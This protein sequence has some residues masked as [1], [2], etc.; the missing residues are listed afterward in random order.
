VRF[1]GSLGDGALAATLSSADGLLLTRRPA[2]TEE[3]SFPTRLVEYLRH[4]RPVFVSNVGDVGRYLR[5]GQDAVL[6]HP[7]DPQRMAD[8]VLEI[9]GR[10]D[11]G[12]EVG[13]RG[14]E[15]GARSF[16]RKVH[17]CRLLEFA[18]SLRPGSAA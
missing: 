12:A 5:D 4:G 17:A 14:R 15:A 11:R 7:S 18:A 2:R 8:A 9:A 6:L 16:D 13:R 3:L 1:R 10:P